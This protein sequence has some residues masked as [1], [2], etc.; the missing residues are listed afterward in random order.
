[1]AISPSFRYWWVRFLWGHN[2]EKE[3]GVPIRPDLLPWA[4]AA[5]K[6]MDLTHDLVQ[7]FRQHRETLDRSYPSWK[8]KYDSSPSEYLRHDARRE[9]F[10]T[11]QGVL[12]NANLSYVF[13]RTSLSNPSWW[14]QYAGGM[15]ATTAAQ[16][17]REFA[18]MVKWVTSHQSSMAVEDTLRAIARAGGPQSFGVL[19]RSVPKTSF[20]ALY[21]GILKTTS[22]SKLEPLFDVIRATRNTLH[23]NGVFTPENGRSVAYT[24]KGRTF[25]F[26]VGK[27]LVW[28]DEE[29]M[30]WLVREIE[31]A[32]YHIVTA[33][34]VASLPYCPRG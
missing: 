29:A 19:A 3:D 4:N 6:M 27:E 16:T 17:L 12:S 18:L 2:A 1:M 15:K 34:A 7:R 21:H 13:M 22:L 8:Q 14:D 24:Y 11:C 31:E 23:T 33:P 32:M 20:K 26:D 5:G 28:L 25:S 30:V 10:V 9:F